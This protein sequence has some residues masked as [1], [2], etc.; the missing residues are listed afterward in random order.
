MHSKVTALISATILG[1][2][3]A[4]A[5]SAADLAVKA[6]VYKAPLILPFSWTGCYVGVEGGGIWGRS[7]DTAA[8]PTRAGF[9]LPINNGFDLSGG[10]VGGTVGCNYQVSNWVF[11]LENDI[12]WTNASGSAS[13]IAPFITAATSQTKEKWLDTLRGRIGFAWDRALFYGT[14]GAAFADT[15][16]EVCGVITCVSDSKTRTGW[17]AGGGIEYAAWDHVTLKLEYLHADF[18][19]SSY[20]NP[21]VQVAPGR[22][23]VTRDVPLT[24]DIVRAGVNYKF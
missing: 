10:L 24:N 14:G 11:G 15:T 13:D 22:T 7:K 12:S 6:P 9:G 16:V 4:T 5:A 8:D 19:T 1:F 17:V 21:S 20:I 18:G 2:G 23:I 3:L